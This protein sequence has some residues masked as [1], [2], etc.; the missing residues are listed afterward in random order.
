MTTNRIAPAGG[1]QLIAKHEDERSA[2]FERLLLL[3]GS[4]RSSR[5]RA[6]GRRRCGRCTVSRRD[7]TRS[8]RTKSRKC[9]RTHVVVG[10]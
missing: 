10:N 7:P 3:A 9:L 6:A 2:Q 4:P 1:A 8:P 5:R